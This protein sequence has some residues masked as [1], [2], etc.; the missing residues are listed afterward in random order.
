MRGFAHVYKRA[1]INTDEIIPARY[2]NTDNEAQLAQHA[3]EDIDPKFVTRVKEGDFIIAGDDFGCGSSREHA[4]WALRGAK[5]GAV[6]ANTFARIF[7]RNAVNNG[8]LAIECPGIARRVH[9]GDELDL[10]LEAGTIHNV[11]RDETYAFTPLADFA[12][13]MI[14]AGGLLEYVKRG[15]D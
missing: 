5:V 3:M 1:H 4:V 2:L 13:K 7:F 12:L 14:Q 11:T 10:D 9:D 8:F 6:V 15:S